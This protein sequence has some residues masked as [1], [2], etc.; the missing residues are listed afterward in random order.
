MQWVALTSEK[1]FDDAKHYKITSLQTCIDKL[2]EKVADKP[3]DD[4]SSI[5]KPLLFI[6]EETGS[7]GI[8]VEPHPKHE[9]IHITEIIPSSTAYKL[10]LKVGDI[11][12]K[13]GS[14][15]TRFVKKENETT[16]QNLTTPDNRPFILE[17][18]SELSDVDIQNNVVAIEQNVKN[19]L[20][21]ATDTREVVGSIVDKMCPTDI[22][23]LSFTYNLLATIKNGEYIPKVA[24]ELLNP[25]YYSKVN[26]GQGNCTTFVGDQIQ[27]KPKFSKCRKVMY[28]GCHDLYTCVIMTP[29]LVLIHNV[30]IDNSPHDL[31]KGEQMN[32]MMM[33]LLFGSHYFS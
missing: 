1:Y 18:L 17:V 16:V 14:K 20:K 6:I 12:C 4:N 10:G 32:P 21:K 13:L 11:L 15:G 28:N 27:W 25:V 26:H 3:T 22:Y 29:L 24:L 8:A 2:E 31:W 9:G 30:L 23:L 33:I 19:I 7:L 5:W